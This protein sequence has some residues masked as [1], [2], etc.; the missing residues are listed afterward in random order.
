MNNETAAI[1]ERD[2]KILIAKRSVTS[3]LPNKWEFPGGKVEVG[4]SPEECL[5]RELLEEFKIFFTV[6][7][8]FAESVYQYER[9]TVRL[10]AYRIEKGNSL[11]AICRELEA[12]GYRTK[13]GKEYWNPKTVSMILKRAACVGF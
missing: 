4:E 2:G 13:T 3:S 10:I 11:R 1:I 5:A 7:N 8:F 12:E 9:K 6:G